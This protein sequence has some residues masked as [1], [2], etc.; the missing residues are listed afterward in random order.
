MIALFKG[1]YKFYDYRYLDEI[2]DEVLIHHCMCDS[3]CDVCNK[4]TACKDLHRLHA[5]IHN[6]IDEEKNSS[7]R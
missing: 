5:Y 7:N 3:K 2:L 4:T 6:V 1:K